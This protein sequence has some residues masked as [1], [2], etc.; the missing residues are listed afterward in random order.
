MT[1]KQGKSKGTFRHTKKNVLH[2]KRVNSK[3][4]GLRGGMLNFF[5]S[6]S[7]PTRASANTTQPDVKFS[8]LVSPDDG[9]LHGMTGKFSTSA[10]L[11]DKNCTEYMDA[12][13]NYQK[14]GNSIKL[15]PGSAGIRDYN[16]CLKVL[17]R[18]VTFD[19]NLTPHKLN[20]GQPNLNSKTLT[21]NGCKAIKKSIIGTSN[22]F[23]YEIFSPAE[24][25][26]RWHMM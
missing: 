17:K 20:K 4:R 18:V 9:T 23:K 21:L 2:N 19:T 6:T 3:K 8:N 11:S 14:S 26:A 13:D 12:I 16:Q 22:Q 25:T 24:T 1:K 15:V 5:R 10:F 7:A